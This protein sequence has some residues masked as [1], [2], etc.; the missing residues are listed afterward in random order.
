M[1]GRDEMH[2]T[3]AQ[4]VTDGK[5]FAEGKWLSVIG[6]MT[7][8]DGD[9]IWTDGKCVYGN[10]YEGGGSYVPTACL[11]AGIPILQHTAYSDY[12][13]YYW[14]ERDKLKALGKGMAHSFMVN[15][16]ENIYFIDDQYVLDAEVTETGDVYTLGEGVLIYDYETGG[17]NIQ[18]DCHVRLNGEIIDTYDLKPFLYEA[19]G[20]ATELAYNTSPAVPYDDP[21]EEVRVKEAEVNILYGRVNE[22]GEYKLV[23]GLKVTVTDEKY[24][25]YE[26]AP[27]SWER[28]SNTTTG[29]YSRRFI[30][31]GERTQDWIKTEQRRVDIYYIPEVDIQ[32]NEWCAP[33]KSINLPMHD[34]W[35]FNFLMDGDLV[36]IKGFLNN[37]IV[38]I[39]NPKGELV[40]SGQ[41][42]PIDQLSICQI[43]AGKY[44]VGDGFYL[45]LYEN[46]KSVKILEYCTNLRLRKLSN[47]NKW[48]EKREEY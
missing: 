46:G 1:S 4:R 24:A 28:R 21:G 23:V 8:S 36:A 39:H 20:K 38:Y 25:F 42:S 15:R 11:F 16:G 41:F 5:V 2:R 37:T 9:L 10:T 7:V 6:N 30:F 48:K 29:V 34:G 45:Y 18:G 3:R 22:R 19:I 12:A 14:L 40:I 27:K 32:S 43:S 33:D 31:D 13:S 44:L 47:I 26:F 35:Y 17:C